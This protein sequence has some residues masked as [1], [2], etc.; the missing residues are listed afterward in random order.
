LQFTD[1]LGCGKRG[2]IEHHLGRGTR[3]VL[4]HSWLDH[5]G[6]GWP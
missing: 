2:E 3:A 4:W 5:G 1:V 6:K